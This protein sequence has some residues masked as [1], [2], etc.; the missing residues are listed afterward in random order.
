MILIARGLDYAQDFEINKK[1][2]S[3]AHRGIVVTIHAHRA[4]DGQT[5]SKAVQLSGCENTFSPEGGRKGR[6]EG[7]NNEIAVQE[8][9]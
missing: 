6:P 7:L 1:K 4:R 5:E 9:S 3:H 8:G 2:E